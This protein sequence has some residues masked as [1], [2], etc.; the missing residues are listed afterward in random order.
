M[1]HIWTGN[2]R[3]PWHD[4]KSRRIY[5]IT[6]RKRQELM[7]FG[8]LEGDY[9]LKPGTWGSP[10]I[11]ASHIGKIIK[12]CLREISSIHSSLRILQYALMPDHLHLILSVESNLD[13]ILGRKLAA[14]KVT[15]NKR[16][17]LKNVFDRGFN[18]QILTTTRKL[19][20]I[21]TYL[22]ENPYRLAIRFAH[23]EF[24]RRINH[25]EIDGKRYSTYGNFQLFT[26][27]FKE[28]VV[29][30]RADTIGKRESDHDKWIHNA[31]NGGVLV[32]PFIS[33]AEKKV[34][35]EAEALG[36]K[37]IFITHEAFPD[38][39]KPA[40]H[41]FELCAEGRLLIIS[42]GHP[43]ETGL[44]REICL[45]ANALSQKI[46]TGMESVQIG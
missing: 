26:N 8:R 37:I 30:H 43:T 32:S 41:D 35:E 3:A 12:D 39:F 28:Q 44:T 11:K 23:P 9:R 45:Q 13:E 19:D 2:T 42:L 22:R 25:I 29:I 4:Y 38:R 6:L 16:A 46:A 21:F 20:T 14:F 33:K 34:R 5:H 24:F 40:Q 1:A 15:V 7:P 31:A 17:D 10:Y 18:D 27:P 36:A